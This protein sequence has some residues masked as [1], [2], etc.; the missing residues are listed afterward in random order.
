MQCWTDHVPAHGIS[1]ASPAR[2][3]SGTYDGRVVARLADRDIRVTASR[4]A[5]SCASRSREQLG[6]ELLGEVTVLGHSERPRGGLEVPLGEPALDA[7]LREHV[8]ALEVDEQVALIHRRPRRV[9]VTREVELAR[10]DD[11]LRRDQLAARD[12]ACT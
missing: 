2:A 3:V 5:T 11:A 8:A 1:R 7:H 12:A 10:R 4:S 6:A 9:V